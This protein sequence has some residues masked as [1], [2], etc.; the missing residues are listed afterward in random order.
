MKIGET[1]KND[2]RPNRLAPEI[3][4]GCL[5][6]VVALFLEMHP[7]QAT[8]LITRLQSL[9]EQA[10]AGSLASVKPLALRRRK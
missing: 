7:G 10:K 9:M 4:L 5:D 1:S 3:L 2:P 8:L 6:Q